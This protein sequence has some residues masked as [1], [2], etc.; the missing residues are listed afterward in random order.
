MRKTIKQDKCCKELCSV[1]DTRHS[2]SF[3]FLSFMK[4]ETK[5]TEFML[6]DEMIG[7][8][9]VVDVLTNDNGVMV[10]SKI[11]TISLNISDYKIRGVCTELE[12]DSIVLGFRTGDSMDSPRT[13][14]SFK[15][16]SNTIPETGIV[17]IKLDNLIYYISVLHEVGNLQFLE[18]KQ[19]SELRDSLQKRYSL[20]NGKI[21]EYSSKIEQSRSE[22]K[23]VQ[24]LISRFE[25]DHTESNYE[26][27]LND[28]LKLKLEI[29]KRWI[30]TYRA[31]NVYGMVDKEF[32]SRPE[33]I[34]LVEMERKKWEDLKNNIKEIT[35]DITSVVRMCRRYSNLKCRMVD[36]LYVKILT[37][38]SKENLHPGRNGRHYYYNRLTSGQLD[39]MKSMIDNL[40]EFIKNSPEDKIPK[41][42]LIHTGSVEHFKSNPYGNPKDFEE[43]MK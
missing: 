43:G 25:L 24:S 5:V 6:E 21:R 10:D 8:S 9:D 27:T 14:A 2:S 23:F 34:K 20:I 42:L 1:T 4:G 15:L 13:E 31:S 11:L 12:Y 41:E 3:I 36:D 28:D 19:L 38:A 35:I 18:Y 40:I 30:E 39:Y 37:I 33:T 16:S 17:N 7:S 32:D 26:F 22:N 29:L